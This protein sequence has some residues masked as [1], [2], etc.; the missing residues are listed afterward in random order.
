MAIDIQGRRPSSLVG[1]NWRVEFWVWRPIHALIVRLCLDLFDEKS[2]KDMAFGH[3]AG[4]T[5]ESTC[6]EM[7]KRFEQWM[8]QHPEGFVLESGIR[9]T[10]DGRIVT[11]RELAENPSLE[12]VSAYEAGESDLRKW[13]EFL[14]NCGGFEI[15]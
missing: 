15:W 5:D 2:L 6:I 14:K 12:T 9:A 3:G 8:R 11:E 13:S 4:A 7:A 10:E 1:K